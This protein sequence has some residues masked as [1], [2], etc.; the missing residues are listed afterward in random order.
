MKK[1][2]L[3]VLTNC[4]P[5]TDAEFNR[6]YNDVHIP[7]VL[8]VPGFT[9]ATRAKVAEA[10]SEG[11]DHQYCA[12]YEFESNDVGATLAELSARAGD[13]RMEMSD[14]IDLAGVSMR[15]YEVI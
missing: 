14:T 13:G 7:D 11:A 9:G 12:I 15:A 3:L 2:K 5:G 8:K 6:W 10:T 1:Y 4:T